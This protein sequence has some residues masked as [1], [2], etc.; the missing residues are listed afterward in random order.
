MFKK[1]LYEFK[2]NTQ[3]GSI[4]GISFLFSSGYL[5]LY[6]FSFPLLRISLIVSIFFSSVSLPLSLYFFFSSSIAFCPKIGVTYIVCCEMETSICRTQKTYINF[7][8]SAAFKNT[9]GQTDVQN[10]TGPEIKWLMFDLYSQFMCGSSTIS[11]I[12]GVLSLLLFLKYTYC[13]FSMDCD[14]YQKKTL[15]SA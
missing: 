4:I 12:L 15:R 1:K 2:I 6:P 3:R 5:S 11:F 7:A 10:E 9:F 13:V 8:N 14:Y